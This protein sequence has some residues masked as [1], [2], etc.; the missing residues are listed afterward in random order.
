MKEG[1]L[2]Q[3]G[4]EGVERG[5]EGGERLWQ[6]GGTE[7]RQAEKQEGR[8]SCEVRTQPSVHHPRLSDMPH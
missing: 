2:V 5:R 3:G 6:G 4:T 8:I 7:G 1:L